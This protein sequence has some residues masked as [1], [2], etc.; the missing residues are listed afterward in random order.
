M[1]KLLNQE[2]YIRP[3][4]F[5]CLQL[6]AAMAESHLALALTPVPEIVKVEHLPD[7]GQ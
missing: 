1:L 4:F 3:L 7:L 5:Q 2:I 6:G